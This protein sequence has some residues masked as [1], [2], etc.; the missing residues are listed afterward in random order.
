M[1]EPVIGHISLEKVESAFGKMKAKDDKEEEALKGLKA[2][3]IEEYRLSGSDRIP[4]SSRFP[5]HVLVKTKQAPQDSVGRVL[6]SY[7]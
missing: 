2:K 5:Y 3:V 6:G 1:R 7:S 4:L